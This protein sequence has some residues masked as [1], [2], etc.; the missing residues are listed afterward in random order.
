MAARA[1]WTDGDL[2]TAIEVTH[3]TTSGGPQAQ[4]RED[5]QFAVGVLIIAL[6][7]DG[8]DREHDLASARQ[9]VAELAV[10]ILEAEATRTLSGAWTGG[11]PPALT[12]DEAEEIERGMRQLVRRCGETAPM[13]VRAR[14]ALGAIRAGHEALT[15]GFGGNLKRWA[16]RTDDGDGCK[17]SAGGES[18]YVTAWSWLPAM[19]LDIRAERGRP[20]RHDVGRSA[21][22]K[23]HDGHVLDSYGD[24]A[25]M[26]A[27]VNWGDIPGIGTRSGE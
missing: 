18:V 9:T 17:A 5:W 2:L 11:G 12:T 10:K 4:F 16:A 14:V 19:V 22:P 3:L 26:Q 8:A 21:R 7:R 24:R 23:E 6:D 25:P 15:R 20:S 13:S 1:S 27:P